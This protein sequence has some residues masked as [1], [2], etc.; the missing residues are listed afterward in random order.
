MVLLL[1]LLV[2]LYA[3]SVRWWLH[4]Q[5]PRWNVQNAP[6]LMCLASWQ[7]QRGLVGMLGQLDFSFCLSHS[8]S[9]SLSHSLAPSLTPSFPI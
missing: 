4:I 6:S 9:L 2:I 3:A 1:V 5:C 8:L 7:G